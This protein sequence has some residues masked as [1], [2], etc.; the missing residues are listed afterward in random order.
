MNTYEIQC[1]LESDALIKQYNPKVFALDEFKSKV[2][3][4]TKWGIFVV[5]DEPKTQSGNH[6]IL[7]F[8]K[9]YEII[10]VDSYGRPPNYFKLEKNLRTMKRNIIRNRIM[11]QGLFSNVCGAYC[12]FF[13]YHLARH[14]QLNDILN[15]FSNDLNDND[16]KVYNF[17]NK[18]FSIT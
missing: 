16:R 17:V 8:I 14:R 15:Y 12:I 5:N 3:T 6:W 13:A 9:P 4:S 10:F 11:I 2:K 7:V 18:K 1:I